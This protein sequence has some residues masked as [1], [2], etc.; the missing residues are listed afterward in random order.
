MDCS[1]PASRRRLL[2]E[3]PWILP[4]FL[5]SGCAALICE[6]S[7]SRQIGLLFGHTAQASAVVLCTYFAGMAIGYA[8]GG[9]LAGHVHAWKVWA[10]A[11]LAAAAWT[12]LVPILLNVLEHS[13]IMMLFST[14][15]AW[16]RIVSRSVVCFLLLLPATTAFGLTLPLMTAC[17]RGPHN[18]AGRRIIVA[19]SLNTLGGFLGVTATTAVLLITLGVR[20]SS[21]AA[22]GLSALCG[23]AAWQIARHS[24]GRPIPNEAAEQNRA[25]NHEDAASAESVEES[26]DAAGPRGQPKPVRPRSIVTAAIAGFGVMA[27]E[28]LYTRLFSLVLH[29]ST[30]T[31]GMVVAVCLLALAGGSFLSSVLL[32]RWP[33]AQIAEAGSWAAALLILLSMWLFVVLTG[34]QYFTFG[35]SGTAYFAGV[36]ALVVCIVLPPVSISGTLLPALWAEEA[37]Q[38]DPDSRIVG[39]L[40]MVNTLAGAAGAAGAGFVLIPGLGLWN[41]FV[42]VSLL[43]CLTTTAL[44]V[45]RRRPGLAVLSGLSWGALAIMTIPTDTAQAAPSSRNGERE[46]VVHRWNSAY[47]WIDV[48]RVPSSG[49]LKIRQNLHYRFGATG[50]GASREYRQARLPLLLHPDPRRVAFL[51]LGTGLTA[52]GAVP[53][54]KVRKIT[55]I[56]LIPE[57]VDA[58][59]LLKDHNFGIVDDPRVTVTVDDARHALRTASEQFDVIIS[60]LFVPWESET[61]YLYT[62]DHYRLA[63]KRLEPGGLFCQWLPVYQLGP[64][65][66]EL[67]AD[68]FATVF[69]QTTLWWGDLNLRQPIL[70]LIGTAGP[71]DV[72]ADA[73][74][75]RLEKIR[76]S[77]SAADDQ[78]RTARHLI[79]RLAGRWLIR[80]P[81]RL[82]T[83]EHPLVE[84][85]APL[86]HRNHRLLHTHR[87][88]RYFDTVLRNLPNADVRFVPAA[89]QTAPDRPEQRRAWH[90]LILFGSPSA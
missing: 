53:H 22:A 81:H 73:V 25:A 58:A 30:Y 79:E 1:P 82:N 47:G 78:I 69:P 11:E 37:R 72:S 5:L 32:E 4:I 70:A 35:H 9:R 23:L 49:V 8:A 90:R 2:S 6:I 29:N 26:V 33:A 88:K 28:I 42:A 67:I 15:T 59:R 75:R 24:P 60:D 13:S 20:G 21:L 3:S 39:H 51:G 34:L 7:W 55:I 80:H 54:E 83:D 85:L 63:R 41:S 18:A 46:Q 61:G 16:I 44:I 71:I 65:E 76:R 10:L 66:L 40:T 50:P 86:S 64:E 52:A 12:C 36:F 48:V 17:L 77:G 38:Q 56:E 68:S 43:F 45:C 57:V 19:W 14:E 62:V 87:L 89:G 31:F 27:L 84:F 74:N